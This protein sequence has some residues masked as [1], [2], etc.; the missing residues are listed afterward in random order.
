MANKEC[1]DLE[2]ART[3]MFKLQEVADTCVFFVMGLFCRQMVSFRDIRA[4]VPS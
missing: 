3:F 1:K 2:A 4:R